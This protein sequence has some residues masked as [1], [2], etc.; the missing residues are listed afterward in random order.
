MP[1]FRLLPLVLVASLCAIV[2]PASA[3]T[4]QT[5]NILF[6]VL[7]DIG[8]DQLAP[9]GGSL[10][11]ETE[12]P[13]LDTIAEAGIRYTSA[14]AMPT[15]SVGR[16]AM[17][18]GRYAQRNGV[19]SAIYP[20][21]DL[22]VSHV[23]PY[24]E[25]LFRLLK[26]RGY[27][28]GMFG[29]YHMGGSAFNP[30]GNAAPLDIGLDRFFG[31]LVDVDAVDKTAG[32]WSDYVASQGG[33]ASYKF[34]FV[35]DATYGACYTDLG[36]QCTDLGSPSDTPGTAVG[37]QCIALGGLL[38]ADT[39]CAVG[40]GREFLKFVDDEGNGIDNGYYVNAIAD[41]DIADAGLTGDETP[42]ERAA[43]LRALIDT[44]GRRLP[45]YRGYTETLFVD[46]AVA[47]IKAQQQ[48]NLPWFA[49]YSATT[50][51]TPYQPPPPALAPDWDTDPDNLP[52][53]RETANAMIK[54]MDIELR[55][56]LVE[57]GLA[58]EGPGGALLPRFDATNT[59]VVVMSDNGTW[60]SIVKL[61]FDPTR[62]KGTPYQTGVW[63]PL[64][65]AG[66][67]V[68]V[69]LKGSYNT[70]HLVNA[71]DVFS[72]IAEAAGFEYDTLQ[73][74]LP[75]GAVLDAA[76][77]LH[78]AQTGASAPQ[79]VRSI[80][81][82]EQ[83]VALKDAVQAENRYA[84]YIPA[85]KICTDKIF[86]SQAICEAQNGIWFGP[87]DDGS[88]NP[89]YYQ[90]CCAFYNEAAAEG[91]LTLDYNGTPLTV[92]PEDIAVQDLYSRAIT[93]GRYKLVRRDE[94]DCSVADPKA[95]STIFEFYE[96]DN[97]TPVPQLDRA[98][99]NLL[100]ET[101]ESC[102]PASL[103]AQ[104]L[105]ACESLDSAMHQLIASEV[106]C[107]GDGNLD[108]VVDQN[109]IDEA[110]RY[111]QSLGESQATMFDFVGAPD[112]DPTATRC[113]DGN[114]TEDEDVAFIQQHLG[115]VCNVGGTP[116]TPIPLPL[117]LLGI[118]LAGTLLLALRAQRRYR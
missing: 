65:V 73:D 77:M 20:T 1:G 97:N 69:A 26:R 32:G 18:T 7:D 16:A 2:G 17:F 4:A 95:T 106:Y 80:N 39:T 109:D 93:D 47:W 14:Y 99:L 9:F 54:G 67:P 15:C 13:T 57:T 51:H 33:S 76:P 27:T 110:R 63:V 59:M 24:E 90:T 56:L 10:N 31:V 43:T 64:T 87:P 61:P 85:G 108:G 96:V 21:T 6:V 114:T 118:L 45:Y 50:V 48:A 70:E 94:P 8:A 105:G 92:T 49:V 36:S 11:N 98:S 52:S 83:G 78:T 40:R 44:A 5:P 101:P 12:A 66:S 29:K 91:S 37:R 30:A 62:A 72:L 60:A 107:P 84:C 89:P 112:C 79:G 41:L 46:E 113:S 23:S 88:D 53:D 75:F 71:V 25:T 100:S 35:D 55:R 58:I 103:D 104:Q 102:D 3:Q 86:V 82:A 116:Q 81:F 115:M 38:A 111:I 19:V 117:K 28:S 68:D 34:G 42:A 74:A 22:P